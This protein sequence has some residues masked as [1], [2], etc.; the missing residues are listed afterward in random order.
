MQKVLSEKKVNAF[1]ISNF[2]NILYLT[3]F[4]TLAPEER[5]AWVLLTKKHVYLFTDGRYLI[6]SKIKE[7]REK[8]EYR[9]ISPEKSLIQHLQ[10][11][12]KGERIRR[13]GFEAEDLKFSEYFA[14]SKKL[15]AVKLVPLNKAVLELREIK[16]N[17]EIKKIKKACDLSTRCLKEIIKTIK[18]GQTEKEIAFRIKYWFK[19]K[20][21]ESAFYPIVATSENAAIPHY[22]TRSGNAKIKNGSMLLIDFGAKFQDYCSDMTR[23][24]FV[25]KPKDELTNVYNK[26]LQAQETTI[27]FISRNNPLQAKEIDK[28]CRKTLKRNSL[29]NFP[30]STGHGVGLQVHESPSISQRSKDSRKEN[31]VFTI[32][33]GVYYPGKFGMRIE[34]TVLIDKHKQPT[35][36]T[37]FPKRLQII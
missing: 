35:V 13:L 14:L 11:I 10:E 2:Y 27:R 4:K 24:F 6:R 21:Y 3:N 5:E 28:F 36:L 8:I 30:H 15:N 31:Q 1:L 18:V 37:K 29:P 17:G 20:G 33:P 32:E 7:Q 16:N 19:E 23:V 26:L 25:G 9:L 22:D 34:D 12:I